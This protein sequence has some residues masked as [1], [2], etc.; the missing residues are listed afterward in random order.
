MTGVRA[1]GFPTNGRTPRQPRAHE[2]VDPALL[3]A[4]EAHIA[5]LKG[6]NEALKGQLSRA[7]A[8]LAAAATDLEAE[9]SRTST[10]IAAFAGLAERLDMLAAERARPW[11]RKLMG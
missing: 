9:R 4:L 8:Q 11:W 2:G 10:A 3:H 6:E 7:G 5:T 1:C